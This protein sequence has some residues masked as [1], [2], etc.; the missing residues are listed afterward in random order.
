MDELSFEIGKNIRKYRKLK[1][2]TLSNSS[3]S[4]T[5]PYRNGAAASPLPGDGFG[6]ITF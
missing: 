5:T 1:G 6:K 2:L 4:G 3:G